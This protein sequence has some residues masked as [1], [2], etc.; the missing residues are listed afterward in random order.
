MAGSSRYSTAG[1][2][3][4]QADRFDVQNSV[5]IE[6]ATAGRD[7][8]A[9]RDDGSEVLRAPRRAHYGLPAGRCLMILFVVLLT[10]VS[11]LVYNMFSIRR[12]AYDI[13]Q[14]ESRVKENAEKSRKLDLEILKAR[15]TTRISY[16]AVQVLGMIP[17]EEAE[18]YYVTAPDTRPF[19]HTTLTAQTPPDTAVLRGGR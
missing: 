2:M 13:S 3:G 1:V 11:V 8:Q 17:Q 15:D 10:A 9:Y 7:Y 12:L 16:H 14:S 5:Y 18:L 6:D 4:V 19:A